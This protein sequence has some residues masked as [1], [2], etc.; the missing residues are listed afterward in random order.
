MIPQRR[1]SLLGDSPLQTKIRSSPRPSAWKNFFPVNSLPP[2]FYS[3]P[4]K[5]HFA[6]PSPL[7]PFNSSYDTIK[8]SFLVISHC[9]CTIFVLISYS[10]DTQVM[11]ILILIDAQYPQNGVFSFQKGSNRK[12]Y[13]TAASFV[14]MVMANFMKLLHVVL[15]YM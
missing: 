3:L 13:S 6:S 11:L 15:M 5:S 2:N 12:N 4:T 14:E 8:T 7:P 1:V 10:F 9:Y